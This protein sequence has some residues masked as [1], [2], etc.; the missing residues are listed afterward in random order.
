MQKSLRAHFEHVQDS[1]YSLSLRQPMISELISKEVAEVFFNID[2]Q[3][4]AKKRAMGMY[5]SQINR[6]TPSRSIGAAEALARFRGSQ[7]GCK[8]AEAFQVLRIIA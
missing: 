6:L 5:K 8:Y 2:K 7:N 1:L 3:L 4:I